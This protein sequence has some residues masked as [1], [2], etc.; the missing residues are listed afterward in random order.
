MVASHLRELRLSPRRAANYTRAWFDLKKYV[1]ER[2]TPV[3]Q[4]GGETLYRRNKP[5]LETAREARTE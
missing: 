5:P 4:V 3:A 2:Y 1:V